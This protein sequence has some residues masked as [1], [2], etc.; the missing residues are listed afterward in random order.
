MF[1]FCNHLPSPSDQRYDQFRPNKAKN[2]FCPIQFHILYSFRISAL[3]TIRKFPNSH[4]FV[5]FM[6]MSWENI[7]NRYGTIKNIVLLCK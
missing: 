2:F 5:L 4:F 7:L 1:R 6:V 3:P